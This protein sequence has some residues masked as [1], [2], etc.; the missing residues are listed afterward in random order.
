MMIQV[1]DTRTNNLSNVLRALSACQLNFEVI[2]SAADLK[3]GSVVVLP[4]VGAF[5]SCMTSL[6]DAGFASALKTHL[7]LG[8][9]LL[10]ICVGMQALAKLST[11]FGQHKGLG[12]IDARVEH[13]S[14]AITEPVMTPNV[15][16]LPLHCD[17]GRFAEFSGADVYFVHSY[18]MCHFRQ[19]ELVVGTVNYGSQQLCAIV[20]Q[21][22]VIGFQFHPEKSGDVGLRILA[23]TI[24][25]LQK[26]EPIP[27]SRTA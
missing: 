9:K 12:L 3:T 6:T 7:T 8:G 10:G 2:Y 11:E 20:D 23:H 13:L 4:G 27:L 24:A 26:S 15:N 1:I 21:G 25:L 5:A 16:W 18:H 14:A 17:S 22:A 19:P